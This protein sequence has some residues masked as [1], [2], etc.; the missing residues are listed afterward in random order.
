MKIRRDTFSPV[1]LA[2]VAKEIHILNSSKAIQEADLPVKLLKDNKDFFAAYMAK[3]FN[4]SLKSAK[5]PNCLKLASITPVF[6]KNARTSKNNYRPVSVLPVISKIFER[7][8]CN[9]LSAFFEEIFS[10]FQ[11]G[12]RKGYSTQHCLLMMLESWKEAV[13]KNQAFGALMT[14][15]SKAFD[16]LSHDLLIAKLHA[17]GID[18][19]SLK[20]LQDYLSNRWQRTKVDSK[21]S[22]WKKI[23]SGV[24]EGSILCL[25]LFNIFMFDMFLFL[26]ETLLAM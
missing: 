1:T 17:Y 3:Y 14:D 20:L 9:Q 19:S 16:C 2:D 4:D 12:F 8:I 25:I 26:H 21:F 24:P 22:S 23:I 18:L 13:D 11:C 5:F 15:L 7:L 10:K 6:K